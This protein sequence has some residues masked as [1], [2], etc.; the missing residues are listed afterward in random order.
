MARALWL[1]LGGGVL[2]T[3]FALGT[4]GVDGAAALVR[5]VADRGVEIAEKALPAKFAAESAWDSLSIEA[6]LLHSTLLGRP[7]GLSREALAVSQ[8]PA[9]VSEATI[10]L[11]AAARLVVAMPDC[12]LKDE[13]PAQL[14]RQLASHDRARLLRNLPK[15]VPADFSTDD[16]AMMLVY[17]MVVTGRGDE[18]VKLLAAH[19]TS[20]HERTAGF[21]IMALRAIGTPTARAELQRI[22]KGKGAMRYMAESAAREQAPNLGDLFTFRNDFPPA[23]R[24]V[25][26]MLTRAAG[27]GTLAILPTATMA[28]AP[29]TISESDRAGKQIDTWLRSAPERFTDGLWYRDMYAVNAMWLRK[30]NTADDWQRV[31]RADTGRKRSGHI[32]HAWAQQYP[33][34]LYA[35]APAILREGFHE[36][37]TPYL[38]RAYIHLTRGETAHSTLD[39]LWQPP[40]QYR[41]KFPAA[42]RAEAR[43][44]PAPLLNMWAAGELRDDPCLSCRLSWLFEVARNEG[45]RARVLEGF[46]RSDK[47]DA[48]AYSWLNEET[49]SQAHLPVLA[50]LAANETNDAARDA[51]RDA[52]VRVRDGGNQANNSR[53]CDAS[54][55]C[56]R[57]QASATQAVP[58]SVGATPTTLEQAIAVLRSPLASTG[59]MQIQFADDLRLE[60]T[61][62]R[63]NRSERWRHWLGC[64]RPDAATRSS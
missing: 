28:F 23:E 54:E 18:A 5:Q 6:K 1:A 37:S 25:R 7:V 24:N 10:Y 2:I 53:C 38:L 59:E 40:Q 35:A 3:A 64:W 29:A 42:A 43:R 31:F 63:S 33:D 20:D 62:I 17:A 15:D 32:I 49:V 55:K 27:A 50:Y 26:A 30:L 34:S 56:L 41:I 12:C 47:R 16:A 21:V 4:R 52:Y 14:A 51:A 57:E 61:V 11:F 36:Y 44:D 48:G 39:A 45:D 9:V 22:A 8:Y 60:A 13:A 19:A 58:A 46:L